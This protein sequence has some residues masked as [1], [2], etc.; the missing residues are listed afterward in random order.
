MLMLLN[1]ISN[2]INLILKC[3]LTLTTTPKLFSKLVKTNL[4]SQYLYLRNVN[5]VRF[6]TFMN[7][8]TNIKQRDLN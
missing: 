3:Y 6:R 4:F 1:Y 5:Y 7:P 8:S 2:C